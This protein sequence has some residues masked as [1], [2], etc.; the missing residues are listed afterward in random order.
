[1]LRIG[2]VETRND[3]ALLNLLEFSLAQSA[4]GGTAGWYHFAG[5]RLSSYLDTGHCD[6]DPGRFDEIKE[7]Y[8]VDV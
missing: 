4:V 1:M 2:L 7:L 8:E 6:D 3:R 5:E